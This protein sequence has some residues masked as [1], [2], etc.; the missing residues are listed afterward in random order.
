MKELMQKLSDWCCKAGIPVPVFKD[1]V[2][3][4]P[5]V[6]FSLVV[7]SSFFVAMGLL[8]KFAK[9]VEGVDMQS[10]LYW[11]GMSYALYFGR[12]VSG[13]G[14]KLEIESKEGDK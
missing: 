8:G 1:P 12:R 4:L 9:I 7:V 14:K 5:S 10:A 13:D 6:S 3:Q 2:S 11:A